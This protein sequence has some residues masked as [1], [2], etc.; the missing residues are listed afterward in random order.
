MG[1]AGQQL[2]AGWDRLVQQLKVAVGQGIAYSLP[3]ITPI[4]KH[5]YNH[6]GKKIP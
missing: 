6:K 1:E 5:T 2:Q 3:I 4:H